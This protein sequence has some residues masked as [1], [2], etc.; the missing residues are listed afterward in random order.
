MNDTIPDSSDPRLLRQRSALDRAIKLYGGISALAAALDL[1]YQTVQ[2]WRETGVPI[3]HC[4]RIETLCEGKVQCQELNEGWGGI[5]E[6]PY[7]QA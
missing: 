4:A 2:G 3:K 5:T 7:A 6:R 1:R